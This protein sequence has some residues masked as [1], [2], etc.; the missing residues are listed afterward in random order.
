MEVA[1]DYD[2]SVATWA[3]SI[4]LR[5]SDVHDVESRAFMLLYL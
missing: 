3:S 1:D 5:E 4:V 2:I